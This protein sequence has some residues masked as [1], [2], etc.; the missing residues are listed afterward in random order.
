MKTSKGM[1]LT[2]WRV[3]RKG[4]ENNKSGR[5]CDGHSLPGER[6]ESGKSQDRKI[7]WGNKGHGRSGEHRERPSQEWETKR[8][9]MTTHILKCI[10]KQT[11]QNEDRKRARAL[12]SWRMHGGNIRAIINESKR[13]A[14]TNLKAQTVESQDRKRRQAIK[15]HLHPGECKKE[16]VR[17]GK[18]GER[19]T[20]Q[21]ERRERKS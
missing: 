11:S 13:N 14:L 16:K 15:E 4:G 10:A 3:R 6:R 9:T 19:D 20:H 7:K 8:A 1:T 12:T 2:N 5:I 21:L 18:E 17:A